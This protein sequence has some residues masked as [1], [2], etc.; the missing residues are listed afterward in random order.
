MWAVCCYSPGKTHCIIEADFW[1]IPIEIHFKG[2]YSMKDTCIFFLKILISSL[3][4]T[5][6]TLN[7]MFLKHCFLLKKYGN[8]IQILFK[9]IK[10]SRKQPIRNKQNSRKQKF[11]ETLVYPNFQQAS[12]MVRAS[13]FFLAL[14][15]TR[16]WFPHLK[17]KRLNMMPWNICSH[18]KIL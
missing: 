16:P 12:C 5:T 15:G 7:K 10:V 17:T 9:P 2:W 4:S 11:K 3:S 18:M 13:Q 6:N 14:E 1:V 8:I